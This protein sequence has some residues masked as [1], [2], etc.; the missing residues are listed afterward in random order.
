M[1]APFEELANLDRL[2]HE[3]ARLAILRAL[4]ACKSADLTYLLS[5]TGLRNGNLYEHLEKLEVGGV[6]ERPSQAL[7]QCSPRGEIGAARRTR[8]QVTQNLVIRFRQEL[9]GEKRIGHFTNISAL[10]SWLP[11]A[12]VRRVPTA[13]GV[14]RSSDRSDARPRWSRDITVPRGIA[15]VSAISLYVSSSTS[16]STITS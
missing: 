8:L 1:S 7:A 13:D 10:H 5:L 2:I 3:P 12:S 6:V 4:A 14:D 11:H 15:S 16:Q 9:L